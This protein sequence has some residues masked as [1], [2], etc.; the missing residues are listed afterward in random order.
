MSKKESEKKVIEVQEQNPEVQEICSFLK[1][2]AGI[3]KFVVDFL[4]SDFDRLKSFYVNEKQKLKKMQ[5]CSIAKTLDEH[6]E[7]LQETAKKWLEKNLTDLDK[8][9]SQT[10]GNRQACPIA[11]T[12]RLQGGKRLVVQTLAKRLTPLTPEEV[13]KPTEI[14]DNMKTTFVDN[15]L[16][17]TVDLLQLR[18]RSISLVAGEDKPKSE[19]FDFNIVLSIRESTKKE[20]SEDQKRE[21]QSQKE[22]EQ[23][24]KEVQKEQKAA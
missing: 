14:L 19:T 15:K 11:L 12:Q 1:K 8:Y 4:K 22:E 13:S 6:E 2:R 20:K 3:D 17:E 18:R 9:A 16:K 24:D 21:E 23:I 10:I 7:T 5:A